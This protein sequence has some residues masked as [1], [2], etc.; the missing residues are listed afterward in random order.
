MSV[1]DSKALDRLAPVQLAG[2][3]SA[4]LA[5]SSTS[6]PSAA[7]TGTLVRLLAKTADCRIVEAANPTALAASTLLLAGVEYYFKIT[8]GNKIAAI[9]DASTDG[10]LNITVL[11]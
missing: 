3:T 6:A 7:L 9:R 2:A 5:F 8:T 4:D 11:A 10:T 1:A